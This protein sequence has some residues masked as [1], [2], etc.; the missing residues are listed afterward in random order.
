MSG[1]DDHKGRVWDTK[2][3]EFNDAC[4][5][6][7]EHLE[8]LIDGVKSAPHERHVAHVTVF[9]ACFI[10]LTASHPCWEDKK[11]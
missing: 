6:I 3:K 2:G 11:T 10:N 1:W 4:H 9:G 7:P 5:A 8:L